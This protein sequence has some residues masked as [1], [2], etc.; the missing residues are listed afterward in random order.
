M[1]FLGDSRRRQLRRLSSR[2]VSEASTAAKD[3]TKP[4]GNSPENK[5]A[6]RQRRMSRTAKH[7]AGKNIPPTAADSPPAARGRTKASSKEHVNVFAF[8]EKEGASSGTDTEHA[9]S[10]IP[11]L[12][13]SGSST[14][15]STSEHSQPPQLRSPYSDLE[16]HAA[17]SKGEFLWYNHRRDASIGSD[18][19][20]SMQSA[21]S[22]KESPVPGYKSRFQRF[23]DDTPT[24]SHTNIK[25]AL[26]TTAAPETPTAHLNH[27][28]SMD[29]RLMEEPEAYY[30]LSPY[31]HSRTPRTV[32]ARN[33][34]PCLQASW[35]PSPYQSSPESVPSPPKAQ[36]QV[37]KSSYDH[38]ASA[39]DS[40]DRRFLTPIYRKFE[41]LNNRILLYLQDEIAEMEDAL[42]KLDT[43]IAQEEGQEITLRRTD[44]MYPSQSK[45]H[46]QELMC[47]ICV[48]V[49]QYSKLALTFRPVKTLIPETLQTLLSR[50]TA[51]LPKA[52]NRP[53]SSTSVRTK[54]GSRSM[55]LQPSRKQIS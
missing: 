15:S 40:R 46:R 26:M 20:M 41:T 6:V 28:T 22:V 1:P 31:V 43:F 38:L 12:A 32:T 8:M 17:E 3:S 37:E 49:E 47:R 29:L 51:I 19:G 18:S 4:D 36:A 14:A 2:S 10:D 54:A 52:W 5:P 11:A 33:R 34:Q 55:R 7:D 53:Q 23:D 25:S 30:G 44:T 21:S 48:K 13:S 45:W 39:I 9:D 24:T 35:Q 50:P 16:V 42:K 27:T